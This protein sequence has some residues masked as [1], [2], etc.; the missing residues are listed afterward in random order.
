M[1]RYPALP[2]IICILSL[3]L[4][5]LPAQTIDVQANNYP[6]W[7]IANA[8]DETCYP[9]A[10]YVEFS[11]LTPGNKYDYRVFFFLDASNIFGQV[12]NEELGSFIDYNNLSDL[13]VFTATSS[14]TG[15]MVPYRATPD[16]LNNLGPWTLTLQARESGS[17]AFEAQK[18]LP[19]TVGSG[20]EGTSEYA[21]GYLVFAG[22]NPGKNSGTQGL[23]K[24]VAVDGSPVRGMYITEP[25]DIDEGYPSDG[26]Y[27]RLAY[28]AGTYPALRFAMRT[29]GN[30]PLGYEIHNNVTIGLGQAYNPGQPQVFVY[31]GGNNYPLWQYVV[32]SSLDECF[33]AAAYV[34]FTGLRVG[35]SYTF[36]AR[37][38]RPGLETYYGY[39]YD[40]GSDGFIEWNDGSNLPSFT[41]S[42]NEMAFWV[43]Y[44]GEPAMLE[45][46][47]PFGE[48]R[49][50]VNISE[51]G[52]GIVSTDLDLPVTVGNK[53]ADG[54]LMGF[55]EAPGGAEAA[56]FE[57]KIMAIRNNSSGF[58]GIYI[59]ENNNVD[60]G[61]PINPGYYLI[62]YP[63][64]EYPSL[65]FQTRNRPDNTVV[66]STTQNGVTITAGDVVSGDDAL[67][68]SLLSFAAAGMDE[69]VQIN[70]STA[71]EVNNLG[72][73]I[74]RS[75]SEDGQF[76]KVAGF[77][78]HPELQGSG[79]TNIRRDYQYID[80][81]VFNDITY[82][83]QLADVSF[84]GV[85]TFHQIVFAIPSENSQPIGIAPSA[86]ELLPN[87]PNPFN[88]ETT[89]RYTVAGD[90]F[91]RQLDAPL[92]ISLAVFNARGQLV[93]ELV[94]SPHYA[95]H[96]STTWNGTDEN[97][98]PVSSGVYFY[99][100]TSAN[101]RQAGKMLLIR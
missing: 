77:E 28:P 7:Q 53:E 24:A 97:N 44:K 85:R 4:Q 39:I 91:G 90:R 80:R 27:Y 49:F 29:L 48:W 19:D 72:F 98:R 63:I 33:P 87:Y 30:Q 71:S 16:M 100:L 76:E 94:N 69:A 55:L 93:K 13:P 38:T 89:I 62:P 68:I 22:D 81:Q 18:T 84:E 70:W 99:V 88:P 25:N 9:S 3:F 31:I 67:P 1:K 35:N 54:Y 47:T 52:S 51:N 78:T 14:D 83:Y 50:S 26:G 46:D 34:N 61:F 11:N 10:A 64:G 32:G 40:P 59:T 92:Q 65:E 96:Y 12:Y 66:G 60:D 79:N 21:M 73:E 23:R 74:W 58:N 6:T 86:Y 95:G 42:S 82:Y 15:F 43:V 2:L 36:T 57:N 5:H 8:T 37:F 101:F 45:V 75:F 20:E 41:A 56:N 17:G